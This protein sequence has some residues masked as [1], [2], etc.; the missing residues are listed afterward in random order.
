[1][2]VASNGHCF[3]T[4]ELAAAHAC[5]A[6]WP[7]AGVGVDGTG[8]AVSAI[9]E[10]SGTTGSTLNLVRYKQGGTPNAFTVGFAGP[11]CDELEWLTHSPF[12]L[13]AT[14]GALIASAVAAVWCAAWA[15]KA[16]IRTLRT[17]DGEHE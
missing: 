5:G 7:V 13:S 15:C 16:V 8:A 9:V 1:M 14:D 2:G 6:A 3:S 10:C 12:S 17:V 11:D 4:V